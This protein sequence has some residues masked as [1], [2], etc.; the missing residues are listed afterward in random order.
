M[1]GKHV[2][3]A[4]WAGYHR[5]RPRHPGCTSAAAQENIL[6]DNR[7]RGN[8]IPWASRCG[9]PRPGRASRPAAVPAI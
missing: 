2:L 1:A 9:T 8:V 4:E 5:A 3:S 7:W 6:H